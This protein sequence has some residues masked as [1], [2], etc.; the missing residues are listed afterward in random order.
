MADEKAQLWHALDVQ[1]VLVYA[2]FL[3]RAMHTDPLMWTNWA[4]LLAFAAPIFIS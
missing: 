4:L 2:P 1:E 3:Q